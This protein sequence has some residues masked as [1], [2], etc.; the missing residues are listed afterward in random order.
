[1]IKGWYYSRNPK[2]RISQKPL[3]RR[4]AEW[5]SSER[6]RFVKVKSTPYLMVEFNLS[7]WNFRFQSTFFAIFFRFF[8]GSFFYSEEE[9]SLFTGKRQ[10][11]PFPF[12]TGNACRINSAA[13]AQASM[14]MASSSRRRT[15]TLSSFSQ[16][17]S[18]S[19]RPK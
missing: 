11:F 5:K 17:S 12:E 1:M 7:K 10:A 3:D 8:E 15:S 13:A 9:F 16:G 18:I 2:V 6:I 4:R 14:A 19:R